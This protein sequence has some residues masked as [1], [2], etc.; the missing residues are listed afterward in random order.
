MKS[1]NW[2]NIMIACGLCSRKRKG[3][4]GYEKVKKLIAGVMSV[5]ML[6]SNCP[7]DEWTVH[8]AESE[9]LSVTESDTVTY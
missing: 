1:P 3:E 2:Y 9:N 4:H 8:I 5:F 6:L 7:M